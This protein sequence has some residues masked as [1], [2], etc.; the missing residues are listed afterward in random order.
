MFD[1]WLASLPF[2]AMPLL[3]LNP[4]PSDMQIYNR[5]MLATCHHYLNFMIK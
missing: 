3:L 1:E 4:G 2:I 5:T